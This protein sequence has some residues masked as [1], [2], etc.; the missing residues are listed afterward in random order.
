MSRDLTKVEGPDQREEVT[1]MLKARL[2]AVLTA[3]SG[4]AL[5]LATEGGSGWGP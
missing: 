2:I 1:Q 5:F 4:L 3:L